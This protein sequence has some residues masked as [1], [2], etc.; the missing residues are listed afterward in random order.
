MKNGEIANTA[1][2]LQ[3]YLET[4]QFA[5]WAPTLAD[6]IPATRHY[7][8]FEGVMAWLTESTCPGCAAGGGPPDCAIRLC[9]RERG[10]AGCWECDQDPCEKLAPIDATVWAPRNRE[11]IR[12][13]GLAGWLAEQAAA[14]ENGFSYTSFDGPQD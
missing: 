12:E 5:Q 2:S 9:A 8:E 7:A 14:V 1:R 13:V 3:Q 6:H 4:Y 11:R 10:Y